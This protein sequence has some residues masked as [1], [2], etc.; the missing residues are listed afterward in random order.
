MCDHEEEIIRRAMGWTT[1]VGASYVL[2]RLKAEGVTF[3]TPSS[4]TLKVSEAAYSTFIDEV[5]YN[6]KGVKYPCPP[7]PYVIDG[8]RA[9]FK[10]MLRDALEKTYPEWTSIRNATYRNLTG[11]EWPST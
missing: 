2:E 7:S 10:V 6:P 3:P 1:P 4:H 11:E 8:L 9:A 5:Y